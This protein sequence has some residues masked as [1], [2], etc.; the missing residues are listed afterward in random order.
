MNITA[1]NLNLLV[2]FEA[3]L[4]ERNVGRAATRIG[5]SQPAMSNALN[6]LRNLFQDS[7]FIRTRQGMIPSPRAL[8]LAEPV[9]NGLAQLREALALSTE[10]SPANSTR[11]FTIAMSDYAELRVLGRLAT[12]LVSAA[13]GMQIRVRRLERIFTAPEELL[14]TGT[15]DMAIGF[16]PPANT[17]ERAIRSADLFTEGNVCIGRRSNPTLRTARLNLQVFAKASHVGIF[18]KPE[19]RGLIDDILLPLRLHRRLAVATPHLLAVP[20]LVAHSDLIAVV[21]EGLAE[22]YSGLLN[23]VVRKLPFKMPP[24][25]MRMLWHERFADDFAHT[26]F[27]SKIL[28]VN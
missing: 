17:L 24:F 13:P 19:R 16:F 8:E 18:A 23:L 5:L 6:R 15:I 21:P 1:V 9:R 11:T 22:R 4:S 26:W 7:L 2:A 10:F 3:L 25:C 27:R 20:H 28:G 14:Q 12:E